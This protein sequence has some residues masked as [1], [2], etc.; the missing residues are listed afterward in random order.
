MGRTLFPEMEAVDVKDLIGLKIVQ[1]NTNL[2]DT[3]RSI[4]CEDA[5]GEVHYIT[6]RPG[7]ASSIAIK[8]DDHEVL[9]IETEV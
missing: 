9:N 5:K 1:V 7:E 4:L 3:V 6:F 2:R 8:L